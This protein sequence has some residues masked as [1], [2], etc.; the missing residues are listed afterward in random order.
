MR[1]KI[2]CPPF[3]SPAMQN[4]SLQLY[5]T[6]G[7]HLCEEAAFVL[8]RLR[9]EWQDIDIAGDDA[10]LDRYGSRIPV[11]RRADDGSELEWPFDTGAV[12]R[13]LED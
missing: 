13:L 3:H 1:A 8:M 4:T 7:C 11:L 6:E 5:G 2:F 9:L 10:L 12:L